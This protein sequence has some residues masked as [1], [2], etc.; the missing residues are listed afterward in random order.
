MDPQIRTSAALPQCPPS[1]AAPELVA[2]V[3]ASG[4]KA[5]LL[6]L[7]GT[8]GQGATIIDTG[9]A[10]RTKR[11]EFIPLHLKALLVSLSLICLGQNAAAQD[12]TSNTVPVPPGSRV[13]VMTPTL[14]TPLIANFLEQRGD[15]LVFIEDGRGRGLWS[16]AISQIQR[17]EITAGEAGRNKKPI[18]K[19]AAI[20]AGVGLA[21]GVLFAAVAEPSDS[22]KEYS[23]I[24]TGAVG[25]VAGAGVGA[26]FGSRVKTERWVNVPLG[27][28]FSVRMSAR[29][30]GI[31]IALP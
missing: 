9:D 16:F 20:G 12:R 10:N 19:G 15:S 3:Y 30:L 24:L 29:R 25:A 6:G 18:A 28:Q 21:L 14:V 31:A 5:S 22:T 2:P 13:R 4:L 17:L 27:R 11:L 8:A 26:Y 23:R 1:A 7:P